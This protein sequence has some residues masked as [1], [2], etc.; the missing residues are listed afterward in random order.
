MPSPSSGGTAVR[1]DATPDA[2]RA[3]PPTGALL[4]SGARKRWLTLAAL[5]VAAVG[6][7]AVSVGRLGENLVY[8]WG[9]SEL[10]AAGPK[11]V[12][13]TIRLGGLVAD[14]S[15]RRLGLRSGVR[16]GRPRR[17]RHAREVQRRPAADVPRADRRGG[18]GN[19]HARRL[20]P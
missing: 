2:E 15:V 8:Y 19:A 17:R 7:L 12:G 11:A 4:L 18:G 10:Q 9:P 14:G 3:L 6:L 20:L 13:A 16:R 5:A 1:P